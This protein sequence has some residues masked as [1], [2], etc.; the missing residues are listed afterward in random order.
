MADIVL[1]AAVVGT[2]KRGGTQK[3]EETEE[4][5]EEEGVGSS[6]SEFEEEEERIEDADVRPPVKY[7][8][9]VEENIRAWIET[10]G[11]RRAVADAYFDNPPRRSRT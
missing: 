7:R 5:E 9:A 3:G 1:R 11:C 6:E 8:K 4:D 2:K 10:V